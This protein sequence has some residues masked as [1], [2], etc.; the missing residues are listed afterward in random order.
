MTCLERP[1]QLPESETMDLTKYTLEELQT[2][3][4]QIP[5]LIADKERET[6]T[7]AEQRKRNLFAD[8]QELALKQGMDINKL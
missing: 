8:L 2:L 5:K 3:L 1:D 6:D 4:T 7:E